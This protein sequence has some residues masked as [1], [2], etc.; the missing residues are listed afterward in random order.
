[1]TYAREPLDAMYPEVYHRVYP[2]VK[3]MC[4]MY[5]NP[6]NPDFY[7]YP[8]RQ[9]VEKMADHIYNRVLM[10]MRDASIEEDIST[11]QFGRGLLRD[12]VL[13][14]LIRELLR[15]RRSF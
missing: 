4:E 10:E 12:L 13:I 7:P 14:L 2:H 3:H 15:R 9:G 11:Q 8:T 1:M 5:D 6:S